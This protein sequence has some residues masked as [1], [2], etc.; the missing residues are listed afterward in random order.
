[1][2]E[3]LVNTSERLEKFRDLLKQNSL[4]SYIVV[5]NDA[6][7]VFIHNLLIIFLQE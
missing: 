1:M 5:H 7:D 6:H 4:D 3:N 2:Q